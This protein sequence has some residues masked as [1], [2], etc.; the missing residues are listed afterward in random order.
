[1]TTIKSNLTVKDLIQETEKDI[2]DIV[3]RV[4]NGEGRKITVN[5]LSI[6]RWELKAKIETLKQCQTIAEEKDNEIFK[7]HDNWAKDKLLMAQKLDDL[8]DEMERYIQDDSS[9]WE[10]SGYWE[11]IR[12]KKQQLNPAQTKE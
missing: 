1:M 11:R 7:I 8:R 4:E 6:D 2:T 9:Y 5:N 12:L 10:D 3:K